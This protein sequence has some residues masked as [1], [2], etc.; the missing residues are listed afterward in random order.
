MVAHDV[1]GHRPVTSWAHYTTSSNTQSS[2]PENGK[3]NCP[4]PVELIE[5]INKPLLLHLVGG[6][7]YSQVLTKLV[8]KKKYIT[9]ATNPSLRGP[10]FQHGHLG[11]IPGQPIW[12]LWWTQWHEILTLSVSFHRCSMFVNPLSGAVTLDILTTVHQTT[13]LQ[14]MP[15]IKRTTPHLLATHFRQTFRCFYL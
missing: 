5:I 10:A 4:K 9:S 1:A 15:E 6:I 12:D 8:Y 7:Y 13:L 14:P 2:A 11:S 3:N